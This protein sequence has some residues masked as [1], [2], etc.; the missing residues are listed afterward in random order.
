MMTAPLVLDT[1]DIANLI[2]DLA[3]SYLGSAASAGPPAHMEEDSWTAYVTI[4]G[5]W[6]GAV[7][8]S[9]HHDLAVAAT[10]VMLGYGPAEVSEEATEDVM[11]ELANVIG[12][13]LKALISASVGE[14][15]K[16][17]LPIVTRGPLEIAGSVRQEELWFLWHGFPFC[18]RL[19]QVGSAKPISIHPT[20]Q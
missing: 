11:G 9:C 16:L 5:P 15:C 1:T 13:N 14:T 20:V 8:L 18:V 3:E 10:S 12:G 4:R 17:S 7:T 2:G 19:V 6:S